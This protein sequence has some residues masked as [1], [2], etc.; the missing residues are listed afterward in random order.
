MI[1]RL[2]VHFFVLPIA[3]FLQ[4]NNFEEA[5]CYRYKIY[6]IHKHQT[7]GMTA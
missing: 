3:Q 4:I 2:S 5:L 6:H 7:K 1:Q